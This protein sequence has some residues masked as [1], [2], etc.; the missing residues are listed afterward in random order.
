MPPQDYGNAVTMLVLRCLGLALLL[1]FTA[2]YSL[3]AMCTLRRV[4]PR[5]LAL[6]WIVTAAAL[7]GATVLFYG[8]RFSAN[9]LL[10]GMFV[11]MVLFPVFT[12]AG[13]SLFIW[14]LHKRTPNAGARRCLVHGMA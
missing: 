4:G 3:I 13:I 11:L 12:T 2:A 1:S 7:G 14:R 9:P 5:G 10:R 8:E 6:M